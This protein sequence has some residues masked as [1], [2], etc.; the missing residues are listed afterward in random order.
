MLDLMCVA[1]I[2]EQFML[3]FSGDLSPVYMD[4]VTNRQQI[5]LTGVI[6]SHKGYPGDYS[7]NINSTV[8]LPALDFRLT[9]IIILNFD[10]FDISD[11]FYYGGDDYNDAGF[12]ND[13]TCSQSDKLF[14][15]GR[16]V[17]NNAARWPGVQESYRRVVDNSQ[18]A[19]IRFTTNSDQY[20][21]EGFVLRYTGKECVYLN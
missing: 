13:N 1:R 2:P 3:N 20:V 6:V 21:S 11:F 8:A 14:I 9:N 10:H 17:C 16:N 18:S 12:Y 15:V 19:V 5:N 7:A 4:E